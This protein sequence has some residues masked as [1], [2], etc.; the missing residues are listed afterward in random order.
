M[1]QWL[2]PDFGTEAVFNDAEGGRFVSQVVGVDGRARRNLPWPVYAVHP[3]GRT[4]VSLQ[5]E[6]SYW[7]RA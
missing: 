6:R 1:L 2:G 4:A 7:F 3:S 5:F